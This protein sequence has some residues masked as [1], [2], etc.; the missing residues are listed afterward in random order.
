M[1]K[2]VKLFVDIK[3]EQEWL[4]DQAGWK[5]VKTNGIRY[6]FEETENQY[7]YEYVYFERSRKELNGII[8]Q[9]ADTRTEL[10]C[11][12]SSWALF[13][14]DCRDGDIRVFASPYDKY[15]MLMV[16]YNSLIALGACYM[17]LGS[18]QIALSNTLN[19]L[20]GI[21]GSLFFLCSALFFLN[22]HVLKKYA[23][24]YDDGTFAAIFKMDRRR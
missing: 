6:L 15:R 19:Y 8:A 21:A 14:K 9:I 4:A 20:F 23:G 5:L 2:M 3:K 22:A 1:K 11:S 12:T 16:K 7:A 18:T 10:V 17:G 24:E 13:R